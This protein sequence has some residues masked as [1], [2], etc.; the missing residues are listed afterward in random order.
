MTSLFPIWSVGTPVRV[1]RPA[2]PPMS[3]RGRTGFI[4]AVFDFPVTQLH[5][6]VDVDGV[7]YD[8]APDEIEPV[9]AA[10]RRAA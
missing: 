7:V 9:E 6:H 10:L 1:V 5:Y 4:V 3:N 8:Y 2:F